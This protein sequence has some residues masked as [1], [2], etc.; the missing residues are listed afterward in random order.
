MVGYCMK[1]YGEK[2]FEIVRHNVCVE[3][4]N[5]CKLAYA[6]LAKAGL[7]NCVSLYRS[8]IVQRAHRWVAFV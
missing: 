7:N 8:N 5:E 2:H 3:D 4:M 1:D 6:K